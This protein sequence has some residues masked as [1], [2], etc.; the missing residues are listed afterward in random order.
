MLSSRLHVILRFGDLAQLW[1]RAFCSGGLYFT[2]GHDPIISQIVF[3]YSFSK[4]NGFNQ[5]K[6]QQQQQ[7]QRHL[8]GAAT[9]KARHKLGLA[10]AFGSYPCVFLG[11]G[12]LG[13]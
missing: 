10:R 7:Q 2:K 6:H 13:R 3:A 1:V 9:T 12:C 8:G 4:L 5:Q 11:K